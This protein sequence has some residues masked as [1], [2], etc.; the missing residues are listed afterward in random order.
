LRTFAVKRCEIDPNDIYLSIYLDRLHY[1]D[2]NGISIRKSGAFYVSA[3]L[4]AMDCVQIGPE[5][6][7]IRRA[8]RGFYYL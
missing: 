6:A 3:E 4:D 1:E 7:E 5:G 2:T 8:R